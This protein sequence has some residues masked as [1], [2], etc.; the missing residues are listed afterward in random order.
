MRCR[1]GE[2]DVEA[3]E[4]ID[5]ALHDR[6]GSGRISDIERQGKGALGAKLRGEAV[7]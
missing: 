1:I 6:P 2:R 5:G 4:S 3:T 7:H